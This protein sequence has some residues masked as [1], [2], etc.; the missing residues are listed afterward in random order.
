[1]NLMH[2]AT[3][4]GAYHSAYHSVCPTC[5]RC[6]T[7]GGHQAGTFPYHQGPTWMSQPLTGNPPTA[8]QPAAGCLGQATTIGGNI[9]LR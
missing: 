8:H 5:G 2:Q 1:M 3:Y 6:P 9:G 4:Q 7:C